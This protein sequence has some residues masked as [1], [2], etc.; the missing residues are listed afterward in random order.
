MNNKKFEVKP[1]I[2]DYINNQV[3]GHI[4][5][6]GKTLKE[7]ANLIHNRYNRNQNPQLIISK[8]K[9]GT[10]KYAEAIE[11]AKVLNYKIEWIDLA[12]AHKNF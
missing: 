12:E 2:K 9:N 11:I 8:L 4:S 6:R 5:L 3:R 1:E 7:V 10:L